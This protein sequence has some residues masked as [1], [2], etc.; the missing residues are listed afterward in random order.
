M[1]KIVLTMIFSF[2]ETDIQFKLVKQKQ[3]KKEISLFYVI[4]KSKVKG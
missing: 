4:E 3:Q 2:K 1:C